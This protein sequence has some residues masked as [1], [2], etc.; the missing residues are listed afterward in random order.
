MET[1]KVGLLGYGTVSSGFHRRL[2][3]V[4]DQILAETGKR[5][6]VLKV[7][8]R[9]GE[10]QGLPL[11]IQKIAVT[12]FENLVEDPEIQI[13]VEAINGPE[14]AAT[15]ICHALE[16]GKHVVSAN[17]A[18]L[19]GHWERIQKAAENSPGELFYEASVC[20]G[21]PLIQVINTLRHSDRILRIEGIVNGTSNYI[22][23]AMSDEGLTYETALEQ[24]QALGYAEADP[25][26]DVDGW[27]AAN[28]L[29]IL[30]GLAFNRPL[31][32]V[33]IQK[34]SLRLLNT[35]K[36]GT[37]LIATADCSLGSLPS[38]S[39]RVL[40]PNHPLYAIEGVDNGVVIVTEGIG[41]LKLIGPGAGADPTGTAMVSDL[42]HLLKGGKFNDK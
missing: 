27:D 35:V 30:S 36:K 19:A 25:S 5:V 29:S 18:A 2:E 15:Y 23:T 41:T 22:L 7:L 28:K 34:D 12:E 4:K 1:I 16:K 31:D 3:R 13:I 37:K 9:D 42:L 33:Q 20:G 26:A 10:I 11:E 14:P 8:V 17:K 21:I 24:A 6:Q 38:V 32:P 39:L 40:E